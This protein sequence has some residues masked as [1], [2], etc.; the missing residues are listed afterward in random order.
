[1]LILDTMDLDQ[2]VKTM[3]NMEAGKVIYKDGKRVETPSEHVFHLKLPNVEVVMKPSSALLVIPDNEDS[4]TFVPKLTRRLSK[5]EREDGLW[6]TD[7]H[8]MRVIEPSLMSVKASST[9]VKNITRQ[10]TT[11]KDKT[12]RLFTTGGDMP[13]LKSRHSCRFRWIIVTHSNFASTMNPDID[14]LVFSLIVGA[15]GLFKQPDLTRPLQKARAIINLPHMEKVHWDKFKLGCFQ[16]HVELGRYIIYVQKA[17]EY[18]GTIYQG[19]KLTEPKSCSYCGN[20][21]YDEYYRIETYH[22][23]QRYCRICF[24]RKRK[25]NI[26]DTVFIDTAPTT[27][28]EAV[29]KR[30]EDDRAP[31]ILAIIR[32]PEELIE[33]D[34]Q[35]YKKFGKYYA[36]P[37]SKVLHLLKNIKDLEVDGVFLY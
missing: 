7:A 35:E 26:A 29:A 5:L 33:L 2:I 22:A 27:A 28:E 13:N 4:R 19:E 21:L 25:C 24:H 16:G 23:T 14:T 20:E 34:G 11:I 9:L 3:A 6:L 12:R 30:I 31:Y 37:E 36:A 17:Y 1:M 10:R 8:S 18:P 15:D 32:H